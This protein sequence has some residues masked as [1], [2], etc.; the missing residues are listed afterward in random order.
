MSEWKEERLGPL[1][2][3]SQGQVI[4][5]KTN[6]LVVAE[7][8]PL[9]R[10]TDMLNKTKSVFIDKNRVPKKNIAIP[11]DIIFTRTGQVGLVFRNQY[12]VVHNNCFKVLPID[13]KLERDYLYWYLRSNA[14]YN[15]VNCIASGSAQPDLP[16]SSF[17]SITIQLPSNKVQSKIASIL[18]AYDG[19]IENN[20]R[21]I[22]LLEQM[23]EEIYKE[24][25][26]RMR[27]PGYENTEFEKG[28]PKGW[29][30]TSYSE[31]VEFKKGKNIT[32][33]TALQG[34]VPVVAGG[35]EPAYYHNTANTNSPTITISASGANAGYVNLYYENIWA[36]DCSFLDSKNTKYIFYHYL[37]LKNRQTEV[38]FLQKGSAQP[39]VYPK[40]LMALKILKPQ[41]ELI[42]RFDEIITPFFE[43]TKILKLQ[44]QTLKQ[45]RDLLLPRLISGKLKV[46]DAEK[47]MEKT[48]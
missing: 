47:E 3:L 31:L 12:G 33:D 32:E 43:E 28:V 10:I 42:K 2:K 14:V 35:L 22:A 39:H 48:V 38:Y 23:A 36:S 37:H 11:E 44:S 17:N 24:W 45:T 18:S 25:F 30:L 6:Y 15:Y 16:H 5:S 34:T 29:E 21:R 9:L 4:N 46:K 41:N 7:G 27:F 20:N 26:V 1:V 13:K 19:L 8:L 40:D